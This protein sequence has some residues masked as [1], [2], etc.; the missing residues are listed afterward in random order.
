[1]ADMITVQPGP[2]LDP[3]Q[4]ALW[5]QHPD[6]PDGEV[7]IAAP[8][9][10]EEPATH[11]V[12][13]TPEVALRLS[14]GRLAEVSRRRSAA[15]EDDEAETPARASRSRTA[16]AAPSVPPTA[17]PPTAPPPAAQE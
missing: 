14:N 6:H 2:A 13:R 9:P 17:P 7:Y 16:A 11:R 4:V 15:A 12:A 3:G 10:G 1:M 8:H 5:E